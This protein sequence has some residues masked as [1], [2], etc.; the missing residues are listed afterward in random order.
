MKGP[1]ACL[2]LAAALVCVP[3]DGQELGRLFFTPEQRSA[4]DARRKARIPDKPAA[5]A[6]ESTVTRVD[7][8]VSRRNGKSTVWVNGEPVLD[9]THPEGL[10]V[11]RRRTAAGEVRVDIGEANNPVD[12]K[13]GQSFDR[14][15][16]AIR[17]SLEG[18]EVKVN[19]GG[20]SR[21][22]K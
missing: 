15:T 12:L 16:G 6:V 10:R 19:R 14:G 9:G 20:P 5:Q 3:A 7:G 13:I 1:A 2:F 17:D 21:Q 11:N 8:L 22:A 4:L 18:G